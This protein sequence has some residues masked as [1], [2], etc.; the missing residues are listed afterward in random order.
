MAG[1]I[2]EGISTLVRNGLVEVL[3]FALIFAV[4]YGILQQVK[5]FGSENENETKKYNVIIALVLGALSILPHHISPGSRYDI[6]PIIE[7]ALPQT[8]LV[9]VAL[10]GVLIVIGL[11][12]MGPGL[13][14]E[15]N[16]WV[17]TGFAIVLVLIVI[18]IFVAASPLG[19]RVP[20]WLDRDVL[21]VVVALAVFGAIVA[22]VMS[23]SGDGDNS[24]G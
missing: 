19:W 20:Y 6:V 17:K 5:I 18:W 8:M 14:D 9:L 15:Q 16:S 21:A 3:I 10:L 1:I 4:V 24:S 11:F 23:G 22:W 12:G 13:L 7:K 2:E